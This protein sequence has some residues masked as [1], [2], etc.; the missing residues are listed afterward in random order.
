MKY[1]KKYENFTINEELQDMMYY[2]GSD[3]TKDMG[4]LYSDLYDRAAASLKAWRDETK[5][6][7]A[8][9]LLKSIEVKSNEP[10]MKRA[11]DNLVAEVSKIS[12]DDKVKI[13]EF[14]KGNIPTVEGPTVEE[15]LEMNESNVNENKNLVGS[16]IQGLGLT[17]GLVGFIGALVT[18][19]KIAIAGSGWPVWLFG[20]SLGTLV[21]IFMGAAVLGGIIAGIGSAMSSR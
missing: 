2:P 11:L 16:I 8:E 12:G 13:M 6:K 4:K 7:A 17:G 15:A 10:E 1:L 21:G 5:R 20:L 19:I 14:S 3:Y 18:V 9:Y